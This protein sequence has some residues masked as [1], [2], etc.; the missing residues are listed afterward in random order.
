[1]QTLQNGIEVPTNSDEYALT[2]HL[3]NMGAKA[4]VVVVVANAAA[5]DALTKTTGLVVY[6]LDV[7]KMEAWNGSRWAVPATTERGR[8]YTTPSTIAGVAYATVA[9]TTFTSLGGKLKLAYTG[10]VE[11]ANS[12]LNRTA[13]VQW[14]IDGTTDFGGV[15]YNVPLVSGVNSPPI[16]VVMERELT[17]GA[18]T[19]TIALQTRASAAGA[20]RN[21]IFSLAV[22]ENP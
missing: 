5:R 11:N 18:G 17:I 20:V 22:S 15:T 6:R 19:H 14:R 13:D 2:Q 12:G 10:V 16:S 9:S 21:V 4:N 8:D 7:A 1:M 3:A